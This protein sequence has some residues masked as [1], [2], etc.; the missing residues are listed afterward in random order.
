[1]SERNI[2]L[3][4]AMLDA[5]VRG[6]Y[7]AALDA[8]D[9][10]VEGDFTHMP[11]GRTTQGR[12]ELQQEVARWQGTWKDLTTEIE[13]IEAKGRNV[14]LLVYQSGVGKGSGAPMEMHYSQV[15]S[16]RDERIV[17]MKTYLDRAEALE[18]AG[19]G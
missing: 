5:F 2:E 18:A 16:I 9:P 4:R 8:F 10:E 17:W 6:D 12:E 15:F 19:A 13:G 1:M 14:L 11:E 7:E 3:I